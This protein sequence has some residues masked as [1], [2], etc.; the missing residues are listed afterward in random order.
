[1]KTRLFF[2]V[3]FLF[4]TVV[5]AQIRPIKRLHKKVIN[6]E[7][8]ISKKLPLTLNSPAD[9][10][11][12]QNLSP[13]FKWTTN[14]PRPTRKKIHYTITI[15]DTDGSSSLAQAI[16]NNRVVF[17][18]TFLKKDFGQLLKNFSGLQLENNKTYIWNVSIDKSIK[19]SGLNWHRFISTTHDIDDIEDIHA[20][21]SKNIINASSFMSPKVWQTHQGNPRIETSSAGHDDNGYSILSFIEGRSDVIKQ[22]LGG[23][24][25]RNRN[26]RFKFSYKMPK[27][28][29]NTTR[30]KVIAYNG[31]LTTLGASVSSKIIGI[32]GNLP[33]AKEWTKAAL[34]IWVAPGNFSKIAVLVFSGDAST[35]DKRK[36][37]S[38][39]FLD[40]FCL[41]ET[42]KSPCDDSNSVVLTDGEYILPKDLQNY[43]DQNTKPPVVTNFDYNNGSVRDLYPNANLETSNWLMDTESENGPC[44]SFGGEFPTGEVNAILGEYNQDELDDTNTGVNDFESNYQDDDAS[45]SSD[46]RPIVYV[47]NDKCVGN[48]VIDASKPFGGKDVVYIHGLQMKALMGNLESPPTFQGKWPQDPVAFYKGGEFYEEASDDYW[49]KHIKR[50]LGSLTSPTN[51]Y[52]KVTYSANQRLNYGVHAV[53]TQINDAIKGSNVGVVWGRGSAKGCFGKNGIVLITHS[54]GGLVASTMLGIAEATR[55]PNSPER[56]VYG[57]AYKIV[58]KIK[59]QIGINAAYA[60]SPLATIALQ[61]S[62][63]GANSHIT[64]NSIAGRMLRRRFSERA[65]TIIDDLPRISSVLHKGILV[66]LM[67]VIS[68]KW[69]RKYYGLTNKPTLT[70]SGGF[71][72]LAQGSGMTWAGKFLIPSFD[73]GVLSMSSQSGSMHEEPIFKAKQSLLLIDMGVPLGFKR[74]G[75]GMERRD[76]LF[77]DNKHFPVLPQ[78]SQTGMVQSQSIQYVSTGPRNWPNHYA[79]I[80]NTGD[81]FDNVNKVERNGINYEQSISGNINNNEESAV[82]FDRAVYSTGALSTSFQPLT[83]EHVRKLTWGLHLP[84]CKITW[85][86]RGWRPIIK[87]KCYWFYKE[88]TIWKRTYH[89]LD[90]YENKLAM[91]Y[92]YDHAFKN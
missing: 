32:T 53:L 61:A 77:S 34:P 69:A 5:F 6:K 31:T 42:S 11:V 38:I 19:L 76:G 66:D 43:L 71:P 80:Q 30:L 78:Y 62:V 57:E 17:Q 47:T 9:K 10:S 74:I 25:N 29:G 36:A 87:I 26:Y 40:R 12:I 86:W 8:L 28:I 23:S 16:S 85:K 13:T 18:K 21:E 72:A 63:V 58:A 79:V 65:N 64:D 67:P 33:Y 90:N 60:G 1:M 89:L 4:Q 7:I 22:Q 70:V 24:V 81:H 84:R 20:C 49:D 50:G 59:G 41:S 27:K 48:A 3:L 82:I 54:T 75:L 51:T 15:L 92:M 73:D 46:L 37:N 2:L 83:N 14:N 35:S 45:N 44:F 39:I 56:Q 68:R 55:N 52:L 88:F 91:D